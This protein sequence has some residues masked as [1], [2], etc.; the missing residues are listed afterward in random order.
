MFNSRNDCQD[1]GLKHPVLCADPVQEMLDVAKKNKIPNIDT[2]CATAEEFAKKDKYDK[3]LIKGAVY[4]FP[5]NKMKEIFSGIE[6]QLNAKEVILI[7]KVGSNRTSGMPFFKKGIEYQ[8]NSQAGLTELLETILGELKFDNEKKV[9]D[10]DMNITKEEAIQTLRIK[11]ISCLSALS[12]EEIE[13]GIEEVEREYDDVISFTIT[14]EMIVD[15][16]S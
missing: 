6:T 11:S 14:K 13:E 5:V 12:E 4:H 10:D 7:D 2:L 16:K 3:L 8:R 1:A 15:R 9:F